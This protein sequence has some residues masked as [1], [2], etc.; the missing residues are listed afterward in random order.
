LD[1]EGLDRKIYCIAAGTDM[2]CRLIDVGNGLVDA[3]W[4]GQGHRHR[5]GA[6]NVDDVVWVMGDPLW[7]IP[8]LEKIIY[9]YKAVLV[10]RI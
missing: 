6:N 4:R 7:H 1:G 8:I 3:A 5:S 9:V 10:S 2:F